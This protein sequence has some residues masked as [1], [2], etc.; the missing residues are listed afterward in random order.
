MQA[1]SPNY[2]LKDIKASVDVAITHADSKNMSNICKAVIKPTD[3]LQ[4]CFDSTYR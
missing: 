2:Y 1:Q 3:R 4:T